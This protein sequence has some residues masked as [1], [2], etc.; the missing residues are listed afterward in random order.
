MT[1]QIPDGVRA[2]LVRLDLSLVALTERTDTLENQ[3]GDL[4]ATDTEPTAGHPD[5]RYQNVHDWVEQW[6][7]IHYARSMTGIGWCPRW[8][9]HPEALLRLTALWRS[10]EGARRDDTKGIASWLV[11]L[12]DPL[13]R[14]LFDKSGTFRYCSHGEHRKVPE[15][16]PLE[17]RSES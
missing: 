8:F 5:W 3:L 2:W 14:E 13:V 15:A 12:A 7:S 4:H 9:D 10:W 11:Y 1:E 6:F 17:V 16:L